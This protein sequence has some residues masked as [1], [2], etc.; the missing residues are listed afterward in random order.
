MTL[1]QFYKS[2][3]WQRKRKQIL[4]RDGYLCVNCKRFGRLRP[5]TDVHHILHRDEFP[6]LRM[7]NSNLISLCKACHN[8]QHPEKGGNRR[9]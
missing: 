7:T 8:K 9:R 1:E 5:A 2:A 6:E 3:E 4:K